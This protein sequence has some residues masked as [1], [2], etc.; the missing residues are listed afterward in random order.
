ML[1]EEVSPV[2]FTVSFESL[3][4]TALAAVAGIA[5]VAVIALR[6]L[7]ASTNEMVKAIF[8]ARDR[9]LLPRVFDMS[10]TL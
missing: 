2:H 1:A 8:R 3:G 10:M 6:A 7:T 9:V 4:D 5:V